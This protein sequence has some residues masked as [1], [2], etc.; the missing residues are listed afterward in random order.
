ML[1]DT[2]RTA[3]IAAAIGTVSTLFLGRFVE[4]LLVETPAHDLLSLG[5]AVAA[6][7]TA[8]IAGCLVP[9]A[10][11]ATTDPAKVLRD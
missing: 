5:G 6:T 1:S 9:A 8:G 2:I 4:S 11:A 7:L 10:R 3:T